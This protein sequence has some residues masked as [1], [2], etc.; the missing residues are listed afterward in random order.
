MNRA[1]LD[2]M[3]QW[4]LQL[5][6]LRVGERLKKSATVASSVWLVMGWGRLRWPGDVLG[7]ALAPSVAIKLQQQQQCEQSM[8]QHGHYVTSF[9]KGILGIACTSMLRGC[10]LV[11]IATLPLLS[12]PLM[13]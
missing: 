1:H 6:H 13:C 9:I 12:M 3:G 11:A 7:A 2:M 5:L 10:V 8:Q 4:A